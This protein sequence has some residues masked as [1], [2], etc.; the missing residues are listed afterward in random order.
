MLLNKYEMGNS[1]MKERSLVGLSQIL[2]NIN[3]K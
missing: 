2:Q 3:P 1:T